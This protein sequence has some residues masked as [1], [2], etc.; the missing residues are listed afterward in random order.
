VQEIFVKNVQRA[1]VIHSPYSGKSSK[2]SESLTYLQRSGLEL[3]QTISIAELDGLPPHGATWQKQG[4]TLAIAAGGDGLIGGVITHIAKTDLP[5]GIMPLGTSN[6]IARSLRIPQNLQQAAEVIAKG[7][8]Q[9]I[10][11]GTAQP[12]EQAPH[13]ASK[14]PQGPVLSRIASQ[15]QAFFAHVLTVGLNVQFA[16]IATNVATRQRFGRL[17][18]PFAAL[19][20]LRNHESLNVELHFDDLFFPPAHFFLSRNITPEPAEPNE[21]TTLRCRALQ[22]AVINAPIFGGQWQLTVPRA[23]PSDRLLDIVVI[24]EVDIED[25]NR[26]LARFF[27]LETQTST[28]Q[29]H[30][31][32][33]HPAELTGIPGIHHLQAKGVVITTNAD[34]RDATLDGEV[35]GQ[36]PMHVQLADERLQVVVP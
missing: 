34:P 30:Y 32:K 13:L 1:I 15:Q 7:H 25:L 24:E 29:N 10:D 35:R 20:V 8:E 18:Y 28:G 36:T 5:L 21:M 22:V 19:E 2:L 6:D 12:A 33:R 3:V 9:A 27:G 23:S 17:T 31:V 16:R 26:Q 14:N 4:I 11:I